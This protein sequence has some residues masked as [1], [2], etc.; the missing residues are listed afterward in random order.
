MGRTRL[1]SSPTKYTEPAALSPVGTI[2]IVAT[3]FNP[4]TGIQSKIQINPPE[5]F[6]SFQGD[7]ISVKI[8]LILIHS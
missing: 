1:K 4:L 6:T 5:N 2:H 8:L 7:L 3:D